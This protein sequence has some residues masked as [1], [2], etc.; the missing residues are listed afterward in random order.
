MR[1]VWEKYKNCKR[2]NV[3]NHQKRTSH[4]LTTSNNV[5]EIETIVNNR[6]LTHITDNCKDALK[7][8]HLQCFVLRSVVPLLDFVSR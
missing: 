6:P 2:I 4:G 5:Y 8:T 7:S 3:L 1:D